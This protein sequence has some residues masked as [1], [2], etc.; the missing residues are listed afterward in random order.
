MGIFSGVKAV[1]LDLDGTLV[2]VRERFYRVFS[3]TLKAHGLPEVSKREFLERFSANQLEDC[4][5]SVDRGKFWR[6]FLRAYGSS[7]RELSKV[8]PGAREALARLKRA[9]FK[10]GV[11]TGRLCDPAEVRAELEAL[12]LGEWIDAVVTK[13]LVE[14]E[15]SRGQIFSRAEELARMLHE[16][17]TRPEETLLVADYVEDIKS[18]KALGLKTVAVLSG[19]SSPELLR[20]AG[21]DLVLGGIKDIAQLLEQQPISKSGFQSLLNS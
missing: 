6:D 21:P 3:D 10:V 14:A 11:I 17:R 16:L 9:G 18:A 2:S 15:L 20:E 8:L 12:G 7:H 13:Q 1:V 4:L 19:S 5:G